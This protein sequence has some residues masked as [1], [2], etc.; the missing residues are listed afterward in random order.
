MTYLH[1]ME[2]RREV[3]RVEHR[4]VVA[5]HEERRLAAVHAG[6]ADALLLFPHD[7]RP[8]RRRERLRVSQG[9]CD[10]VVA[11]RQPDPAFVGGDGLRRRVQRP[12]LPEDGLVLVDDLGERRR[13]FVR[14]VRP[15]VDQVAEQ[16]Q[17]DDVV[18]RVRDPGERGLQLLSWYFC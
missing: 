7:L 14:R 1:R 10:V 12:A 17:V 8:D 3:G 11:G 9:E 2:V 18:V 4:E 5:V 13:R 15:E 6:Q 16:Y